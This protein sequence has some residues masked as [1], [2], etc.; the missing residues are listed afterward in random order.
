MKRLPPAAYLRPMQF[1]RDLGDGR[2]LTL[3]RPF[4]AE[5]A[6]GQLAEL[7][8]ADLV[9]RFLVG[10]RG[11]RESDLIPG[12][13]PEEIE[14]DPELARLWIQDRP[15]LWALAKD[16]ADAYRRHEE[17]LAQQGKL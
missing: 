2:F 4:P 11:V 10:W 15:D 7:R 9:A 13:D 3:R 5:V 6:G 17:D 8:P 16:I 1:E 12:G 14:F